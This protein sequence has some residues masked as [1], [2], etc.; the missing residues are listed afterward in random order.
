MGVI[1]YY[2]YSKKV[3]SSGN[4]HPR[5]LSDLGGVRFRDYQKLNRLSRGQHGDNKLGKTSEASRVGETRSTQTY[6]LTPIGKI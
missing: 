6:R 5:P 3:Y 2:P 4:P 1:N